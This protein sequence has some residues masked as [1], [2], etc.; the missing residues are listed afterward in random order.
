MKGLQKL[1]ITLALAL[2]AVCISAAEESLP[3]SS[4]G[5]LEFYVD[6]ASFADPGRK[7]TSYVEV[8]YMINREDLTFKETEGELWA[9]FRIETVLADAQGEIQPAQVQGKRT[10]A[11]SPNEIHAERFLIT[12]S[13][14]LLEPGSYHLQTKIT[15]SNSDRQGTFKDTIA[16]RNYSAEVLQLSDLEMATSITADSSGREFVK[17]KLRVIPNAI[18]T[19]EPKRTLLYFYSEIYNL[20]LGEG[21]YTTRYCVI[22]AQGKIYKRLPPK[23][24]RKP[25]TTSVE[26]GGISVVAFPAGKYTLR[27]E[28]T[29]EA[30]GQRAV[31]EKQFWVWQSGPLFTEKQAQRFADDVKYIASSE[32]MALYEKS[33]LTGKARLRKWFWEKRDPTPGTRR[34]EVREDHYRRLAYVQQYFKGANRGIDSDMGRVYIICGPPDD[35]ERHLQSMGEKPYEIWHYFQIEGGVIFIFVDLQG[36]GRYTL[37]HSTAMGEISDPDWKRWISVSW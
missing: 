29:D 19:Y 17:N 18:Q 21:T 33:N 1:C 7:D 30:N 11:R 37:L 24:K 5:T 15:D 13:R 9:D 6:F 16:V 3:R 36:F 31:S 28:I 10:P 26:V 27:L 22:D 25:G 20:S 35:V 23:T 2:C 34:N 14:F 8:Y 12:L 32:E 4:T